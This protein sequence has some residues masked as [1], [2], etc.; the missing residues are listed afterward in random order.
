MIIC[1]LSCLIPV[2]SFFAYVK[3]VKKQINNQQYKDKIYN[4]KIIFIYPFI[5]LLM[6]LSSMLINLV[7]PLFINRIL[8]IISSQS[9]DFNSLLTLSIF[10][11]FS[12]NFIITFLIFYGYG[13]RKILVVCASLN[14]I[15]ERLKKS[16][17]FSRYFS[18]LIFILMIFNVFGIIQLLLNLAIL[19]INQENFLLYIYLAF[20]IFSVLILFNVLFIILRNFLFTKKVINLPMFI[21]QK[22]NLNSY[23]YVINPFTNTKIQRL[24]IFTNQKT[25][26]P[27]IAIN[28]TTF[29]YITNAKGKDVRTIVLGYEQFMKMFEQDIYYEEDK[30]YIEIKPEE[31]A[32]KTSK[33][34]NE[35]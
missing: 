21:D 35:N 22:E 23:Q 6:S 8:G 29:F 1:L 4:Q 3:T 20:E 7:D 32:I 2:I 25:F 34:Q 11:F 9:Q 5:I 12:I 31:L 10:V 26:L 24:T 28:N 17:T 15:N 14:F 13:R 16:L 33:E 30:A 27:E 18:L 19:I